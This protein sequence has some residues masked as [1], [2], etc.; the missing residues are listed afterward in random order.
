[1]PRGRIIEIVSNY[2]KMS[3]NFGPTLLSWLERHQP[4][5][6]QAILEADRLSVEHFGGHGS[7]IAQVYNHMIMP[8]ANK[9]DKYTQVLWGVRDFEKR[10]GRFP[11]GMW[12]PETAV[13]METLE[14][15][16]E[17][18]MKF[19][20][21]AP[22]Q[23]RRVRRIEKEGEWVDVSGGKIDPTM[24]YLFQFPSGK[25]ITLFFYDGPISQA[26][27]FEGLL[28][29][30]EA[31]AQRLVGAFNDSRGW[32]QLVH[33][34]TDG[35]TYGHHQ[36]F[37]DMA[38]A[39]CLRFIE[40]N[41][42]AKITNYG[43]YLHK[44]PPTHAV[45]I[46]EN[47]S[48]SCVHGVERWRNDCGCNSGMRPGWNQQWRK[49]MRDA[50]DGLRDNLAS[51]YEWQASKYLK[52]PWE[53]RDHYIDILLN[54]SLEN[55]EA[56]FQKEA[57]RELT[58]EEKAK[59]LKLLEAQ[60]NG[61]L[62]FTSC[63]WFFDEISGTETTQALQYSARAIQLME[64]PLGISLEPDYLR[65][66]E[67]APS[68]IPAFKNG[69]EIYER[70]VKSARI[71]LLRV[72]A[73]Y[74]I[75]SLFREYPETSHIYSYTVQQKGFEKVTA[76]KQKLAIGKATIYSDTTWDARELSFAVLHLGDHNVNGGIGDIQDEAAFSM[77]QE[78]MRAAFE[79][80]DVLDSIRLMDKYFGTNNYSL[81]HLFRDEQRKVI[82]EILQSTYQ[83]IETAYRQ[84][85]E[86]NYP[87]FNFLH[88]LNIP[89]SKPFRMA[90]EQTINTDL[91][92]VFE[93]EDGDG[94]RLKQLIEDVGKWS[95]EIDQVMVEFVFGSWISGRIERLT[96]ESE[97]LSL[98]ERIRDALEQI[99]RVL[100]SPNLL[101]AQN[102][103]FSLKEGVYRKMLERAE[104]GEEFAKKWV[105]GFPS[106][107]E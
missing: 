70:F 36:R 56:F 39:Y 93:N 61:M 92:R 68:N 52:K 16:A 78:E 101:K 87:L 9:R 12:L 38:L 41:H 89:L 77:M 48:W 1:M 44:F 20:I 81:W 21:L 18:G 29:S 42:L 53:A 79:K 37:G 43:E 103:Y 65:A 66:L 82:D 49:P 73:H 76:G 96:E 55:I 69:A 25:T 33:V 24:A 97:A 28:K 62:M 26:I 86:N 27:A 64:E 14:V 8:L 63:G 54:R 74:A 50:M 47:S 90:A 84:I 34:A 40:S 19:T 98:M 7:A 11:E 104:T 17:A 100:D 85:Y 60:R 91:R 105:E 80:G 23:A 30:G 6:Y 58:K 99:R 107:G 71:D 83:E 3:F 22:H 45:E 35:E 95:V 72:G 67:K 59:V 32:P 88:W 4:G 75:S 15:L 10:F 57:A 2:S 13:D 102:L 106:I 5:I 94:E 46:V 51:L 31:F